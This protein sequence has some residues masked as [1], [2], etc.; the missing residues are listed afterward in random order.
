MR[1]CLLPCLL[2]LLAPTPVA[3]ALVG[4]TRGAS[5]PA[6]HEADAGPGHGAAGKQAAHGGDIAADH[7]GDANRSGC[8]CTSNSTLISDAIQQCKFK[9]GAEAVAIGLIFAV[10]VIPILLYMAMTE[11]TVSF[12]VLKLV[13]TTISIFLALLW[14]SAFSTILQS[15]YV[16]SLFPYAEEV[17]AI[18]QV[19]VLYAMVMLIAYLWR[20]KD[21]R[22]MTLSSCGAHYVAF[23]GIRATGETQFES[24]KYVGKDYGHWASI[25][26][27][28]LGFA[29]LGLVFRVF[30][31]LFLRRVGH[32]KLDEVVEEMEL[33][34]VGLTGSFAVTQVVRQAITGSYPPTAHLLL[35]LGSESA[36]RWPSLWPASATA[37]ASLLPGQKGPPALD[38]L[39]EASSPGM[40]KH[41]LWQRNCMLIWAVCLTLLAAVWLM[42][43][44]EHGDFTGHF[45]RKC[46]HV[47]RVLLIMCIAW[48]YLLWGQWAFNENFFEGH[49]IIGQMC[50][51]V[52]ATFCSLLFIVVVATLDLKRHSARHFACIGVMGASLVAAWSWEHVFDGSLNIIS[53]RYEVGFGGLV[54]KA[55]LALV[56]PAAVLPVYVTYIKPKIMEAQVEGSELD[57]LHTNTSHHDSARHTSARPTTTSGPRS[58]A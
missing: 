55:T 34:I 29:C 10:V 19:F 24:S 6:G 25:V 16:H 52:V 23:A 13:D 22:L 48:G 35:F 9:E 12:L 44:S 14:F 20:D 58:P 37:S 50:F 2:A 18:T 17:F 41:E 30:H 33:D 49:P 32:S 51:A 5:R 15:D 1:A 28:A 4:R 39:A 11:G 47:M 42:Y 3:A 21:V 57:L 7:L 8:N 43:L 45:V 26:V 53:E 46:S 54:P 56:I 27:C 38:F 31:L 40:Q 36:S